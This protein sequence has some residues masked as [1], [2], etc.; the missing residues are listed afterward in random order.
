MY[1]FWNTHLPPLFKPQA[2]VVQKIDNAIHWINL[3]RTDSAINVNN[4]YILWITIYPV[5]KQP[6]PSFSE[7]HWVVFTRKRGNFGG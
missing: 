7:L 5:D 3:Y 1:F 6:E 2:P 4:N